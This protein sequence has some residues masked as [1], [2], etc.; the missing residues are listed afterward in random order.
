[1]EFSSEKVRNAKNKEHQRKQGLLSH[2]LTNLTADLQQVSFTHYPATSF[3]TMTHSIL[4]TIPGNRYCRYPH[5]ADDN[6]EAQMLKTLPM[7]IKVLSHK[8][9]VHT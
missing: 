7:V 6:T 5:S 3:A 1:M 9:R 2:P 8:P 4:G